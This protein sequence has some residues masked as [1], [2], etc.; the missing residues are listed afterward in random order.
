MGNLEPIGFIPFGE[1]PYR[2]VPGPLKK[3]KGRNKTRMRS[4]K[5]KLTVN[6]QPYTSETAQLN[7]KIFDASVTC[8]DNGL[9]VNT[10]FPLLPHDSNVQRRTN[11]KCGL[12]GS[13]NHNRSTCNEGSIEYILSS[14]P[15][16][17]YVTSL[18]NFRVVSAEVQKLL[19]IEGHSNLFNQSLQSLD[20]AESDGEVDSEDEE[21]NY[22]LENTSMNTF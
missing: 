13:F 14:N 19:S 6:L 1:K 3:A 18:S 21:G 7:D 9:D 11:G 5:R 15:L 10:F 12:C 4:K 16:K 2:V 8:G 20:V 17:K 22:Y